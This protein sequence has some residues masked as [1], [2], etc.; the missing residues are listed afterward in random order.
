MNGDKVF[1]FHPRWPVLSA[2]KFFLS[3]SEACVTLDA[4]AK[5]AQASTCV[6]LKRFQASLL[7]LY[8]RPARE[9]HSDSGTQLMVGKRLSHFQI[10]ETLGEGAMGVV[11]KARDTHLGR[12]VAVKILTTQSISDPRRRV[13]FLQESKTASAVNHPNL[14]HIYDVGQAEG[15][16]FIAMEYVSGQT[17]QQLIAGTDCAIPKIVDYAMQIADGLGAAHAVGIL[18]RDVKPAN[19]MV[20]DENLIKI[21]DF[22]L[23][24]LW[25]SDSE[26]SNDSILPS[27]DFHTR[28]GK[29][30]GTVTYMSPE[31][32]R[33]EEL[34]A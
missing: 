10:L 34:D 17:L 14:V 2:T 32:A 31:Q 8:S 18:H 29:V 19:I 12:L 15:V 6:D 11:Y 3:T 30:A 1:R 33:G 25:K 27:Q 7:K 16:D 9:Y 5:V 20:H 22:G 23:A 24:K 4:C 26:N 21:L 13:R 28:T